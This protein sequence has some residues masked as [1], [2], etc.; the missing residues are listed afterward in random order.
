MVANEGFVIR[1]R[2][3][4]CGNEWRDRSKA[5]ISASNVEPNIAISLPNW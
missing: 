5:V 3:H 1:I 4:V 2:L